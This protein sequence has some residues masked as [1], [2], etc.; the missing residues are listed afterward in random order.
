MRAS[1][2]RHTQRDVDG[3]ATARFLLASH[4]SEIGCI[5]PVAEYQD[6]LAPVVVG[7]PKCLDRVIERLPQRRPC[8]WRKRRRERPHKLARIVCKGRADRGLGAVPPSPSER[9]RAQPRRSP[10]C[11]RRRRA[12]SRGR[13]PHG[14][15]GNQQGRREGGPMSSRRDEPRQSRARPCLT[16]VARLGDPRVVRP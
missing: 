12:S 14:R 3:Q 10:G 11:E 5:S 7:I 9:R 2:S 15:G 8:L 13:A 1:F 6:H 16:A 4:D